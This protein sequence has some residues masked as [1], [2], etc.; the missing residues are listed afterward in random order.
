MTVAHGK[1][2]A[3]RD[4]YLICPICRRN[5]RLIQVRPETEA[6]SLTVFCRMCKSEIKIDI[7]KGQCFESQGQ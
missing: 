1:M 6:W 4:G 3:V 7:E 5:T 2:L